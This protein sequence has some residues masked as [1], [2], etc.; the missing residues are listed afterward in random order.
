M[1]TTVRYHAEVL[2]SGRWHAWTPQV[3]GVY[4]Y[5]DTPGEAVDNV[6]QSE[7]VLMFKGTTEPVSRLGQRPCSCG[8]GGMMI[9]HEDG[10]WFCLAALLDETDA[11]EVA[12]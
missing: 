4:G 10:R 2:P 5:G 8:C 3:P 7:R 9:P 1:S 11:D 12:K 6:A